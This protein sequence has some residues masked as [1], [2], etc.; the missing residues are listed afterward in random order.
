MTPRARFGLKSSTKSLATATTCRHRNSLSD[1]TAAVK[2]TLK[3]TTMSSNHKPDEVARPQRRRMRLSHM[4]AGAIVTV[5]CLFAIGVVGMVLW[6]RDPTPPPKL[7][8]LAAAE[9]RWQL[10]GPASYDLEVKTTRGDLILLSVRDSKPTTC[11]VNGIE[12]RQQRVWETWTVPRQFEYIREDMQ[13]PVPPG[14]QPPLIRVEFDAEKGLPRHYSY[15]STR[16]T[17]GWELR[18]FTAVTP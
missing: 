12:P 16:G 5:G 6:H 10:H 11:T 7:A 15:S 17:H 4:V 2:Y 1:F 8:D 14:E 3:Y 9:A 13:R 18:R